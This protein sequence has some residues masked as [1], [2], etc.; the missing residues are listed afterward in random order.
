MNI[1]VQPA[2]VTVEVTAQLVDAHLADLGGAIVV[3]G[4]CKGDTRK[5]FV[6]G[7]LIRTSRVKVIDMARGLILTKNSVYE[8][9]NWKLPGAPF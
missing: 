4:L 2:S 1:A 3:V 7:E 8:V 6:D 9:V 5:R